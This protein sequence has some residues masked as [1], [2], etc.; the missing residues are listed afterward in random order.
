MFIWA[1]VFIGQRLAQSCSFNVDN[2]NGNLEG[3]EK[4]DDKRFKYDGGNYKIWIYIID[5]IPGFWISASGM[6]SLMEW[7]E[8]MK[9]QYRDVKVWVG[10]TPWRW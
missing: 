3:F 5:D 10:P 1:A 8:S 2:F 9:Q 6:D 4:V 7:V